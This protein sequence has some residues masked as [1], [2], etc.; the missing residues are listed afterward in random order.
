MMSI[1]DQIIEPQNGSFSVELARYVVE[2]EFPKWMQQRHTELQ[3]K[4]QDATLSEQEQAELDEYLSANALLM[5][6]QSKGRISLRKH[7]TA[8]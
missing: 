5:I 8:A 2:L 6:L 1:L 3:R 4:A 7:N